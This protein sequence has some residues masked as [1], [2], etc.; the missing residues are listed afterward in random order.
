MTQAPVSRPKHPPGG[1]SPN[2]DGLIGAKSDGE[3]MVNAASSEALVPRPHQSKMQSMD[4]V[5]LLSRPEGE[6]H[7]FKR[8][9]SSPQGAL[10]TIP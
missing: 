7:E 1:R 10:K 5:S 2:H 3:F 9:L 8:D 4:L 6:T